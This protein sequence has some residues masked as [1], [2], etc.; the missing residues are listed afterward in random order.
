MFIVAEYAALIFI[1]GEMLAVSNIRKVSISLHEFVVQ[2][3]SLLVESYIKRNRVAVK[4]TIK[5][6][7]RL[8]LMESLKWIFDRCVDHNY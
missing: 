5:Q 4:E 6:S 7:L 2:L 8:L 1:S 3:P